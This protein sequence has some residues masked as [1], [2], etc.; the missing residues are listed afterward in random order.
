MIRFFITVFLLLLIVPQTSTDNIILQTFHS[1]KLFAN[2]GQTKLFLNSLTWVSI[3]L[4]LILTF[5]G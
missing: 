4:Y 1:T 3:L 5:L 2:Y